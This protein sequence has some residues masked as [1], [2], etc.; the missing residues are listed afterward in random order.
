MTLA[1]RRLAT[2]LPVDSLLVALDAH[3]ELWN[4]CRLRTAFP[5]SPHTD[6][7]DILLR[8]QDLQ[9]FLETDDPG[10][11]IDVEDVENWSAWDIL[12]DDVWPFVS[13][14][15]VLTHA[16]WLGRVIITR[17][18]PGGHILP[19]VDEGGYA[20]SVARCHIIVSG[21]GTV[22]RAGAETVRM[23]PGE[24]WWFDTSLEH[25][26]RNEGTTPRVALIV[27][28]QVREGGRYV[29]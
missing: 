18:R 14:V 7:D 11:L 9:P 26:V 5:G 12:H 23:F 8:F 17:L 16:R 20:A 27:D 13:E 1:F 28:V 4:T 3:P 15:C 2:G 21:D 22:F 25:E 10:W 6:V 29:T 24:C 19:H